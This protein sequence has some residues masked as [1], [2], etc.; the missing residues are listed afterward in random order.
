M[1]LQAG[2]FQGVPGAS[3]DIRGVISPP[4]ERGPGGVAQCPKRADRH[5]VEDTQVRHHAQVLERARDAET[6]HLMGLQCGNVGIV[7][8]DG[9]GRE[10]REAGDQIEQGG[11]AGAV[12]ADEADAFTSS[13]LTGEALNG[14]YPAEMAADILDIEQWGHWRHP[15]F[16]L[17]FQ[18]RSNCCR[19]RVSIE[20]SPNR[21]RGRN[22]MEKNI[23]APTTIMR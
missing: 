7:K 21:P 4:G 10:G 8:K 11:L 1:A 22:R 6:G 13:H 2:L 17:P 9:T 16:N 23:T 15:R 5:V 20:V 14:T 19:M 3:P 12:R 18:A